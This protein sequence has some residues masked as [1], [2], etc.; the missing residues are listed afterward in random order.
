MVGSSSDGG[1]DGFLWACEDTP[2]AFEDV[3][4]DDGI[5]EVIGMSSTIS[6]TTWRRNDHMEVV[7]IPW[8]IGVVVR[9]II[10]EGEG[11]DVEDVRAFR[12]SL[13]NA[14]GWGEGWTNVGIDFN[15][16][17]SIMKEAG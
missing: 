5:V 16:D 17:L 10:V 8:G 3:L 1:D 6:T 7:T 14:G 11:G 2:F 4:V 15:F 13:R 12:C 9:F